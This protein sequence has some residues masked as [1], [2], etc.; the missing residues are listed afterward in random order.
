MPIRDIL[1]Q[2]DTSEGSRLRTEF[3]ANLAARFEAHLTGVFLRPTLAYEYIG[4]GR[5]WDGPIVIPESIVQDYNREL[6]QAELETRRQFESASPD[7]ADARSWRSINGDFATDMIDCMR[8]VDL[9]IFP[10]GR[11][12]YLAENGLEPALLGL[13]SGGPVIVTP[14]AAPKAEQIAR[15]VLVAW[16]G[17]REAARALRDAWPFITGADQVSVLTVTREPERAT[18]LDLMQRFAHH[19]VKADLVLKEGDGGDAGTLILQQ[20]KDMQADFIVMGLYGHARF[21]ELV[22]GGASRE[23]LK[24]AS[25]PLFVSH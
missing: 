23:V 6:D 12:P 24:G 25:V 8:H 15:R 17:R 14:N 7:R 9:T 10:Q 13:S 21:R 22:L 4:P 1:V 2:T 20:A 11:L 5:F 16:D 19:G 3:A 18:D